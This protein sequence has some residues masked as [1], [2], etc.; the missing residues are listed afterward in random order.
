M[1]SIITLTTIV[2]GS[3]FST[4]NTDVE[5]PENNFD[6]IEETEVP[7]EPVLVK[8]KRV[9]PILVKPKIKRKTIEDIIEEAE[10]KIAAWDDM[11]QGVKFFEGYKPKSYKCAAGV[12]TIGYGHTGKYAKTKTQV[13]KVEAE[14]MLLEELNEAREHVLRIVK[15]PLNEAQLAALTSFTFNAGQGNLRL[16]VNQPNRLNSGNYESVERML[17][18]YN[19][20]GGRTLKGLTKRRNWEKELWNRN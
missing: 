5:T 15:V 18:K 19:K 14:A 6:I 1:K 10:A 2:G 11:V 8:P 20:G 16:L 9:H 17:P 7:T 13:S 4:F 12:T 3:I